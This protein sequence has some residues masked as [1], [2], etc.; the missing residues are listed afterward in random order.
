[1]E[2]FNRVEM[3]VWLHPIPSVVFILLL[4]TVPESPRWLAKQNRNEGSTQHSQQD[5]RGS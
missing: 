1:M 2:Y 3:D 5:K 4:L